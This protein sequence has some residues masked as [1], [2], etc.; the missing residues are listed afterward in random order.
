M[1]KASKPPEQCG[2]LTALVCPSSAR[3]ASGQS[4]PYYS[5]SVYRSREGR[6]TRV[7]G[8]AMAAAE[9]AR[10]RR[11]SW[12]VLSHGRRRTHKHPY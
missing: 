4:P 10:K 1:V 11:E 8:I 2:N 9:A 5:T 6:T 3:F 7:T 12:F